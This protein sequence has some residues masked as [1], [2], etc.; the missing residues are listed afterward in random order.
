LTLASILKFL[1]T[2]VR[3]GGLV[4]L[5]MSFCFALPFDLVPAPWGM[6]VVFPVL[7]ML[8]VA[9]TWQAMRGGTISTVRPSL[10]AILVTL[11][12]WIALTILWTVDARATAV[13]IF[14]FAGQ[15]ITM[16]ALSVTLAGRRE[17]ALRWL[18]HGTLLLSILILSASPDPDRAGR[19]SVFGIDENATGLVLAV[20]L[21]AGAGR[22]LWASWQ[23]ASWVI[24]AEVLVIAAAIIKGGSRSAVVAVVLIGFGATLILLM[25]PRVVGWK[26]K[27]A[28]VLG[29]AG[30]GWVNFVGLS[31]IGLVPDRITDL[32]FNPLN[33]SDSLRSEITAQYM[34]SMDRWFWKGVGFGADHAYIRLTGE[35]TQNVHHTFWK[36]W[37]EAGLIG[38][39]LLVA[40]LVLAAW[41]TIRRNP[42]RDQAILLAVPIAVFSIL[43]GGDRITIFWF[44]VSFCLAGTDLRSHDARM[45]GDAGME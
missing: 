35:G 13:A 3:S 38:L 41:T 44:V 18:T 20:G 33:Q 28:V 17:A 8:I 19:T 21:A 30:G 9:W 5:T 2:R 26:R 7:S 24:V 1:W 32:M 4:V 14:S 15:V 45:E 6:S 10:I 11:V 23:R 22:L 37:V 34:E 40:F 12:G 42:M 39:L 43:L 25:G 27:T 31:T 36:M 16:I 29:A